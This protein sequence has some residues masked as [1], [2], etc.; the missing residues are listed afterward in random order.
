MTNEYLAGNQLGI[1][2]PCHSK[3]KGGKISEKSKKLTNINVSVFSRNGI[4]LLEKYK[5]TRKRTNILTYRLAVPCCV[6]ESN[7]PMKNFPN[8]LQFLSKPT[9]LNW[10]ACFNGI[11]LF[12]VCCRAYSVGRSE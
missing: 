7:V 4:N 12:I 9:K 11:G 10:N 2:N 5:V 8:T 1:S 3:S 6:T